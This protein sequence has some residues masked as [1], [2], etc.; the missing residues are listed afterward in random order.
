MAWLACKK[1]RN[2][3]SAIINPNSKESPNSRNTRH[4]VHQHFPSVCHC[5]KLFDFTSTHPSLLRTNPKMDSDHGNGR[6]KNQ[7]KTEMK[8]SH[9]VP[10]PQNPQRKPDWS[11]LMLRKP[12]WLPM[13]KRKELQHCCLLVTMTS[14][15][16]FRNTQQQSSFG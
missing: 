7:T 12:N 13:M 3:S 6:I 2:V 14:L 1:C 4:S 9:C 8:W 15:Q 10:A 16:P 11:T 5:S